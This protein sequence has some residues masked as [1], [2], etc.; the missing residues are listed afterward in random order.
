MGTARHQ[1]GQG[2]DKRGPAHRSVAIRHGWPSLSK[3][4]HDPRHG[5]AKAIPE[6]RRYAR[7]QANEAGRPVRIARDIPADQTPDR[8][9]G[10]GDGEC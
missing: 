3:A 9:N 10:Q 7:A 5:P 4:V 1:R 2:Q 8:D 6:R